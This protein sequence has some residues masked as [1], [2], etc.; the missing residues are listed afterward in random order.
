VV[1]AAVLFIVFELNFSSKYFC[2]Y[3]QRAEAQ[4][5]RSALLFCASRFIIGND[6]ASFYALIVFSTFEV[7]L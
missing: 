3:G 2:C 4:S 6:L 7:H 5:A 1:V